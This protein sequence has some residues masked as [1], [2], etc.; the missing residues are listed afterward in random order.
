[1]SSGGTA[2]ET[3][4]ARRSCWLLLEEEEEELVTDTAKESDLGYNT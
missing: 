2:L 3:A 1:L 4:A